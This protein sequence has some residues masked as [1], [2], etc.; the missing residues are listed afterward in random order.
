MSSSRTEHI[1]RQKDLAHRLAKASES[2]RQKHKLIKLGKE[3]LEQ[4]LGDTF[5]PIVNPL[6]KLVGDIETLKKVENVKAEKNENNGKNDL[7]KYDN[8][9]DAGG[10]DESFQS[11]IFDEG[12]Q[13]RPFEGDEQSPSGSPLE[14]LSRETEKYLTQLN[15][16]SKDFDTVYGVR[17]LT[18]DRLMMGNS[19]ISFSE[20]FIH[21]AD[22]TFPS[23][24]G[25][26]ELI[27]LKNP[28]ESFLN[29][30]DLENYKKILLT[31]NAHKK[32]YLADGDVRDSK[33]H[34][35]KYFI[36]KLLPKSRKSGVKSRSSSGSGVI[37]KYMIAK[38][39]NQL[40]YI[41]WDDPNELVD[42]LRLLLAS[43]A[44][45]NPSHINEIFSIIEELRE[46][47]IIY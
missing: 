38:E 44:A 25:L 34:K 30:N 33:S 10:A 21:I 26:L 22:L 20:K 23:S 24:K 15:K 40:Y 13:S 36:E 31:T 1:H 43:Q 46:A 28:D 35:F 3:S 27:F 37:P 14:S 2:I 29:A 6:E 42:R 47:K 8:D 18:K 32:H 7:D 19:P 9:D 5:K 39:S 17:K 12:E 16:R 11:A 4:A 45:G 41:Y